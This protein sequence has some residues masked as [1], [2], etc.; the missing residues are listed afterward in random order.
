MDVKQA[1]ISADFKNK[2]TKAI[3]SIVLF[4]IGGYETVLRDTYFNLKKDLLNLQVDLE[5]NKDK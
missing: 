3:F 2:L 1:S 4:I 5:E